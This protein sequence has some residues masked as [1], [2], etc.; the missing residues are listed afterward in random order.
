MH[1]TCKHFVRLIWLSCVKSKSS[2]IEGLILKDNPCDT[3][4]VELLNMIPYGSIFPGW[5]R[6]SR[7]LF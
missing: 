3:I 7:H 6:A 5:S 1:I 4:G 2:E